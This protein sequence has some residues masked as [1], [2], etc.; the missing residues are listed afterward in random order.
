MEPTSPILQILLGAPLTLGF[1]SHYFYL[2]ITKVIQAVDK[3]REQA[4]LI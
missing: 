1:S 2:T 3:M 4:L